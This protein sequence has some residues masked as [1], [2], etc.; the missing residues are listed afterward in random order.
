MMKNLVEASSLVTGV[1]TGTKNIVSHRVVAD[2]LRSISFL[3]AEG[4]LPSNEG[5]WYVLRRIMR[6]A[7]RHTHILGATD[8]LIYKLVNW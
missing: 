3:I 7:M 1:D 4:L 8:P 2:H 5:M 6:R